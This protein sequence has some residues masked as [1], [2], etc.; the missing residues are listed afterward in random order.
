[1][2]WNRSSYVNRLRQSD[3]MQLFAEAGFVVRAHEATVSDHT[4]SVSSR[5]SATCTSISMTTP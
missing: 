2:K 5:N 4:G 3:W 1:M